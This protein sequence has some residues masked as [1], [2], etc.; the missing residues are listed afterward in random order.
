MYSQPGTFNARLR[1]TDNAG[2]ATTSSPVAI[3]AGNSPPTATIQTPAAGTTW[4][5][6][7]LSSFTG[8]AADPQ[9]GTLPAASLSWEL[10]LFHCP[11]NCHTHP[12]QAWSGI[13]GSSF[14]TP[15]HEYPAYIELRLT[16]TDA[17][18]LTDTE[19]RRLDPRTSLLSFETSPPGLQLA[20]GSTM[21]STPFTRQVIEGSNNTVSA[22]SPQSLGGT[23]YTWSG[24][25]DAGAESHNVVAPAG[26]A[27]YLAGFS[28]PAPAPLPPPPAPRPASRG[29]AAGLA[30][31]RQGRSDALR[32]GSWA[33]SSS[34]ARRLLS[35]SHCRLGHVRRVFSRTPAG[36]VQSQRPRRGIRLPSGGRVAVVVSRGPRTAR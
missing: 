36:F 22:P 33:R 21:S 4:K 3:A 29:A 14:S 7:R 1:V 11:S 2:Q 24:W 31:R 13:A 12:L 6:G 9:Q 23:T 28:A 26:G 16:A 8:S 34:R 5:V 15:D 20:V 19:V 10:V 32:R 30:A 18:G 25:S 27:S 35:R 17:G